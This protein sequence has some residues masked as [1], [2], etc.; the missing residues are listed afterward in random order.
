MRAPALLL[1]A[2][3]LAASPR[4]ATGACNTTLALPVTAGSLAAGDAQEGWCS[5]FAFDGDASGARPAAVC[6]N[7]TVPAGGVF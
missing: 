6:S 7:L 4:H 2:A 5:P 3:L 1:A